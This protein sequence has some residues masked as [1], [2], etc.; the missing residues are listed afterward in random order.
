MWFTSEV[1]NLLRDCLVRETASDDAKGG[2]G[3]Q[4]SAS[5]A[6]SLFH[7]VPAAWRVG[8][9]LSMRGM[10]TRLGYALDVETSWGKASSRFKLTVNGVEATSVRIE[11]HVGGCVAAEAEVVPGV[12]VGTVGS[13]C[14]GGRGVVVLDVQ[15]ARSVTV[16]VAHE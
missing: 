13:H 3:S 11:V 5:V 1:L 10:P 8:D 4:G 14:E 15:R 2:Q 16:E 7:A 9:A 12:G 6:L